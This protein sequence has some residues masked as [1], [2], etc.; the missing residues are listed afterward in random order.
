MA[1]DGK[2]WAYTE[3]VKDHFFNPR[4][5]LKDEDAY[6][7]D[8]V[9]EVG[10]LACGDLMKMWIKVD[11]ETDVITDV[12]W[13][14]FGCASAIG[15]TSMLSTMAPGLKIDD[16]LKIT[17]QDIM[18]KLGGLPARKIHCSV[19]G[20]KALRGAIIDY[21]ERTG[22]RDR[23]EKLERGEIV[24]EC[25][26]VTRGDIEDAVSDGVVS[27]EELQERTKVS[28][29]CGNCEESVREILGELLEKH[30]KKEKV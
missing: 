27:F 7:S 24:C 20:D 19:L 8:G 28:T 23:V 25:L 1:D 22:Q 18:K 10:S 30:G 29:G 5:I 13:K 9:G 21:L 6:E 14:T 3:T 16:A 17:P 11:R 15:S 26:T 2:G 12:K 4:N